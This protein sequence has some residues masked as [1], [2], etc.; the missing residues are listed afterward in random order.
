M[1]TICTPVCIFVSRIEKGSSEIIVKWWDHKVKFR[2]EV[3]VGIMV[4][5][6]VGVRV[7]IRVRAHTFSAMD[8]S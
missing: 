2:V 4:G 1:S 8:W 5:V 3:K 7:G 6:R